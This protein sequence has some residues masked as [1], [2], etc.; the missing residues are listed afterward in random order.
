MDAAGVWVEDKIF[1][2]LPYIK[3]QPLLELTVIM[4]QRLKVK[5]SYKGEFPT[6]P[7]LNLD[8]GEITEDL[9]QHWKRA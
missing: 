4:K 3:N 5:T 8:L 6:I 1:Q 9:F 2:K 7:D